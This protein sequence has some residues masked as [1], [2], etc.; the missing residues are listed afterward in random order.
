MPADHTICCVF[1]LLW[2][3]KPPEFHFSLMN[4]TTE[5]FLFQFKTHSNTIDTVIII[6]TVKLLCHV[7]QKSRKPLLELWFQEECVWVELPS[8]TRQRSIFCC[9]AATTF[10]VYF[11]VTQQKLSKSFWSQNKTAQLSHWAAMHSNNDGE[12]V[13]ETTQDSSAHPCD[14]LHY[15]TYMKQKAY[16]REKCCLTLCGLTS[17]KHVF[18]ILVFFL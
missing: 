4:A 11:R 10:D 12:I 18:L 9:G 2:Q 6:N 13:W 17:N 5:C 1:L 16:I 15:E 7:N 3:K 8:D 14:G